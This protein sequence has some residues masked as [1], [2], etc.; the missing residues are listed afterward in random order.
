MSVYNESKTR[1]KIIDQISYI[2][3]PIGTTTTRYTSIM[4]KV[5]TSIE[6][7]FSNMAMEESVIVVGVLLDLLSQSCPHL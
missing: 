4:T 1:K 6:V 7:P 2:L 3:D 5:N